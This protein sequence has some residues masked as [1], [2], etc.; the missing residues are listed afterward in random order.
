MFLESP[1]TFLSP[2]QPDDWL[3]FRPIATDPD[4]MRY[5]SDGQPWPDE[6]IREFV[7]RQVRCFAERGYCMWKMSLRSTG[8]LIGF[9]GI[10]PLPD[11]DEIEIGWWLA[12]EHWGKGIATE[13][14][15]TALRDAFDRVGLQR[16]VAVARPDNLASIRIMQ[17]LGMT[18]EK[19]ILRRGI[20]SVLYS[21]H[22]AAP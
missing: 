6:R 10:Q 21:L 7:Q 13:V 18:Y 22:R 5:I 4:V 12:R 3:H 11:S 9:C 16:V 8:Q 19:D 2:W 15:R 17:K 14:A 20:P 1:R